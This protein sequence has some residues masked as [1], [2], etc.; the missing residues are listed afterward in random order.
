MSLAKLKK[1]ERAILLSFENMPS[2]LVSRLYDVGIS[3]GS[4]VTLLNVLN[5]GQLYY[6][7]IDDVDFCIRKHDAKNIMVDVVA[8]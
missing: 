2:Q 7:S 5:F 3:A 8:S 4:E 1:G 6:I